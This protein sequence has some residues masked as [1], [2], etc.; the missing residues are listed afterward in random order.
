MK[1]RLLTL[2]RG[3]S[4]SGK[5]RAAVRLAGRDGGIV[6]ST[7]D[8]WYDDD[9]NYNFDYSLIGEAH[10][11]AQRRARDNM[12]TGEPHVIIDNTNARWWEMFPYLEMAREHDYSVVILMIGGIDIKDIAIYAARNV[13][14]TPISI[15]ERQAKNFELMMD[16]GAGYHLE[17]L[18][19]SIEE[20]LKKG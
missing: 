20:T 8:F 16:P 15:I 17:K 19:R 4:G 5:S 10:C 18:R 9:G 3:L 2:M 11:H 7:D 1:K 6:I 13:H 12:A 14:N